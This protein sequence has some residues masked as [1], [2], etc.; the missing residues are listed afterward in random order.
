M[1]F[2]ELVNAAITPNA[3]FTFRAILN[4]AIGVTWYATVPATASEQKHKILLCDDQ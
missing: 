1:M 2:V 4:L 3:Y